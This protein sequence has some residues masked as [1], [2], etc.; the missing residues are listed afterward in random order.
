[1]ELWG[2]GVNVRL[3]VAVAAVAALVVEGVELVG[4]D[5]S[6]AR[7]GHIV[8]VGGRQPRGDGGGGTQ[9]RGRS[10]PVVVYVY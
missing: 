1:M 10:I 6:E 9:R 8:G 3:V 5:V 2:G 7:G 4:S